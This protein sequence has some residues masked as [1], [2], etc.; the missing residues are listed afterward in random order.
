MLKNRSP[1]SVSRISLILFTL[2]LVAIPILF[3]LTLSRNTSLPVYGTVADFTLM[4]RNLTP[5][6]KQYLAERIWIANFMFTRCPGKCPL[7]NRQMSQLQEKLPANILLVSFTVDPQQD[8]PQILSEYAKNYHPQAGRWFF[9]TGEKEILDH[10]L[11]S[12][13]M[14]PLDDPNLHSLKLVLIDQWAQIRGYY[15]VTDPQAIKKLL[16]D[17]KSLL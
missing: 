3:F 17:A 7:M 1:W 5:V 11:E 13:H 2:A 8:T 12:F 14:S 4:E 15:E 16:K 10:L 6:S 9:L